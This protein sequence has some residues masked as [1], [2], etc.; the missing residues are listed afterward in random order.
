MFIHLMAIQL[1]NKE[2]FKFKLDWMNE[3]A[4]LSKNLRKQIL[5]IY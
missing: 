1:E 4:K 3:I 5:N 2:K